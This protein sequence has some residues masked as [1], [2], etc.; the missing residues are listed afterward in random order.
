MDIVDPTTDGHIDDMAPFMSAM[1]VTRS[2]AS[3]MYVGGDQC[4]QQRPL[5][6]LG[7]CVSETYTC[8]HCTFTRVCGRT[9]RVQP[10]ARTD[11][12]LQLFAQELIWFDYNHDPTCPLSTTVR[13]GERLSMV[14]PVC[15]SGLFCF[16]SELIVWSVE[17]LWCV[18]TVHRSF[19]LGV[20]GLKPVEIQPVFSVG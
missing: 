2:M 5:S 12:H 4:P 15:T 14:Y 1:Y 18:R 10:S 11:L 13:T 8:K 19:L 3:V 9:C 17:D 16:L 20:T 7:R 6:V